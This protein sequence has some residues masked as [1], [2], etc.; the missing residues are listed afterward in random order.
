[1]ISGSLIHQGP[2]NSMAKPSQNHVWRKSSY[3]DNY[4][5]KFKE[6]EVRYSPRKA[7]EKSVN[8]FHSKRKASGSFS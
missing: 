2:L 8:F 3:E 7:R 4:E 5:Y 1:M 6:T